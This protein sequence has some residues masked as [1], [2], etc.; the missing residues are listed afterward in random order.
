MGDRKFT[1]DE[2]ES[3]RMNYADFLGHVR[4]GSVEKVK[5]LL[6]SGSDVNCGSMLGEPTPLHVAAEREDINMVELLLQFSA[7][8][9]VTDMKGSSPLHYAAKTSNI[10]VITRLLE[11]NAEPSL[12]NSSRETPAKLCRPDIKEIFDMGKNRY[13]KTKNARNN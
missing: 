12:S 4:S 6:E 11:S 9:N 2:G 3:L 13:T 1:R 10:Q 8:V 7:F 5:E